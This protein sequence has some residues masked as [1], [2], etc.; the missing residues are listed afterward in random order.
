MSE[1]VEDAFKAAQ[2][3][4]AAATWTKINLCMQNS[5]PYVEFFFPVSLYLSLSELLSFFFEEIVA[6]NHC[7]GVRSCVNA[8][9]GQM[10]GKFSEIRCNF[11]IFIPSFATLPS[12]DQMRI[13]FKMK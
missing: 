3:H 5:A 13:T 2:T 4:T 6:S 7:E 8:E 9:S 12:N 1:C 10:I 11:S